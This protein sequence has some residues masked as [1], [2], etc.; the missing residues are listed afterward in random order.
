ASGLF[1][2]IISIPSLLWSWMV[3]NVSGIFS[4]PL[5][6]WCPFFYE[7]LHPFGL[8]ICRKC[9]IEVFPL[10]LHPFHRWESLGMIDHLFNQPDWDWRVLAKF[11]GHLHC[12]LLCNR[13]IY[14]LL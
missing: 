10:Q 3:C 4:F 9:Q 2:V 8:I 1:S 6:S 7:S 13:F 11:P 14:T 12:F 5:E